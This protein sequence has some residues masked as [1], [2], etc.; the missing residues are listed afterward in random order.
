M[1]IDLDKMRYAR[2]DEVTAGSKVYLDNG[3]TCVASSEK[4]EIKKDHEGLYF[5]CGEGKH[6]L[7]GQEAD[8]DI[9]YSGIFVDK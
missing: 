6:Y 4:T 3:F 9:H 5:D 8:D 1:N 2:L 7:D